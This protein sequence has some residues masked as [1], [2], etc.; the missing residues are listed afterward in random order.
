MYNDYG[1]LARDREEG[2]LSCTDFLV[3]A[4]DSAG[5]AAK[6]LNGARAPDRQNQGEAKRQKTDAEWSN[7]AA[8]DQLMSLAQF[9]R[10]CMKLALERLKDTG[11]KGKI[12]E[13]LL[14]FIDIT[15]MF[16]QI[17]VV[18]DIGRRTSP[19]VVE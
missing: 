2:N 6:G 7:A 17:Y 18:K 8:K 5:E 16:G 12:F 1:S 13:A 15:D 19:K 10:Q 4:S 14:L 3:R 9:E 11:L